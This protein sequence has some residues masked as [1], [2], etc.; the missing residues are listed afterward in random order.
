MSK[1]V[2]EA[3]ADVP[4]RES[5]KLVWHLLQRP[6]SGNASEVVLVVP[7][8]A[9][10]D[11]RAASEQECQSL[12]LALVELLLLVCTNATKLRRM[13]RGKRLL[14][15]LGVHHAAEAEADHEAGPK[16]TLTIP[17]IVEVPAIP[18]L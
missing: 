12:L 18:H 7:K 15:T 6:V 8:V 16:H 4:T 17:V 5:H 2:P 11:H 10:I 3:P 9:K 1:S 13:S 14:I